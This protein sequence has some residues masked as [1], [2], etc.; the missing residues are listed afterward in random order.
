MFH[1]S[2]LKH[3]PLFTMDIR[4][5]FAPLNITLTRFESSMHA[6]CI[7]QVVQ[8]CRISGHAYG[9]VGVLD[10]GILYFYFNYDVL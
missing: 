3:V 8:L 10:F 6:L 9:M 1:S 2:L 5:D 4:S 7:G